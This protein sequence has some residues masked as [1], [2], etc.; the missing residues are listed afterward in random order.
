MKVNE[1]V[2]LRSD[3]IVGNVYGGIT[4]NEFMND[5]LGELGAVV[6]INEDGTFRM[7]GK[8]YYFSMEMLD[9]TFDI[10]NDLDRLE[11]QVKQ[12]LTNIKKIKKSLK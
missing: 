4:W 11:Y 10:I 8:N 9:C 2:R 6:E 3:L 12:I 7:K 1:V 5:C